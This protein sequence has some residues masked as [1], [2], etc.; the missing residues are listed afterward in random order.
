MISIKEFLNALYIESIEEK[1]VIYKKDY[2]LY[3]SSFKEKNW[4]KNKLY[5]AMSNKDKKVYILD[6]DKEVLIEDWKIDDEILRFVTVRL[7]HK[8]EVNLNFISKILFSPFLW[9]FLR[10]ADENL[11][12][13]WKKMKEE[14]D[15]EEEDDIMKMLNA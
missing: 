12:F 5:I 7:L 2:I 13:V 8:Y 9:D 6:N 4:M 3:C 15:I 10:I 14:T 11:H 1:K